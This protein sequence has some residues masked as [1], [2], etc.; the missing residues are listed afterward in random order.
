MGT[1][2]FSSKRLLGGRLGFSITS[3]CIPF[4]KLALRRLRGL[5]HVWKYPRRKTVLVMMMMMMRHMTIVINCI[6]TRKTRFTYLSS[7]RI[8]GCNF[9]VFIL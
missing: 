4:T 6:P 2:V 5:A 9:P 7:A 1:F 8:V 3:Y